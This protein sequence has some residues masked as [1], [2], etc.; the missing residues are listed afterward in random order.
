M[1]MV[2]KTCLEVIN[3]TRDD[4]VTAP[5]AHDGRRSINATGPKP[6]A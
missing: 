4:G 6:A 5:A 3:V 1:V 2:V